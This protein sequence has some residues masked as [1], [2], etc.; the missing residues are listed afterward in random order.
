MLARWQDSEEGN[1]GVFEKLSK[2]FHGP[3][4]LGEPSGPEQKESYNT[5]IDQF[6][7]SKNYQ[8][9]LLGRQVKE[10]NC[11]FCAIQ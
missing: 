9:Y 11:E 3:A 5:S 10:W 2:W 7:D 6:L 4:D 8:L 1:V